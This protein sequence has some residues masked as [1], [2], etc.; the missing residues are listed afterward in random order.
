VGYIETGRDRVSMRRLTV[1]LNYSF[2]Q[3]GGGRRGGR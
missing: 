1:S 2:Q 3:G